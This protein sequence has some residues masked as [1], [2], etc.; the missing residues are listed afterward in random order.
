[1]GGEIVSDA[2]LEWTEYL[3]ANKHF[4][5]TIGDNL[6]VRI[7]QIIN[8]R[9]DNFSCAVVNENEVS[10]WLKDVV[11]LEQYGFVFIKNGFDDFETVKLLSM[12]I[13]ESIG[14]RKIG[15]QLKLKK[16]IDRLTE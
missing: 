8:Q 9:M 13:M 10:V 14:I 7:D 6:R 4:K 1:M 2:E 12:D 16:Y 11:N 5:E 15:H 3:D